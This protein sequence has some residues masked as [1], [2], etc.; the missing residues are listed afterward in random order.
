MF[1]LNVKSLGS[2]CV[3]IGRNC[4]AEHDNCT[5]VGDEQHTNHHGQCVIGDAI[6]GEQI[7]EN[8]KAMIRDNTEAFGW[9][10]R[11]IAKHV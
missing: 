11:V 4:V 5:V 9:L 7:P 6:F 8:V 2:N 1:S 10:L 3:L